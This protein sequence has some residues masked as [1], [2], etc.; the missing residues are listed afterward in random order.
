[1]RETL[2]CGVLMVPAHADRMRTWVDK[3]ARTMARL[4]LHPVSLD[5]GGVVAVC[6]GAAVGAAAVAAAAQSLAR[7]AMALRRFDVCLLPVSPDTLAWTRTALSCAKAVLRTP[8]I[9]VA[10]GLKAAAVEDLLALGMQDFVRDPLCP[11]ELRVRTDRVTAGRSRVGQMPRTDTARHEAVQQAAIH[12]AQPSQ[13]VYGGQAAHGG[14]AAPGDH[15]AQGRHGSLAV[16]EPAPAYA[17]AEGACMPPAPGRGSWPGGVRPRPSQQAFDS[18]L[19]AIQ[20]A[21]RIHPDE[22]FRIAKSRVVDSFERDYVRTALSRHAGNVAR[23]A[24]ASSKH[25]RAFWALMRKHHIDAA[26]YRSRQPQGETCAGMEE[27]PPGK[28]DGLVL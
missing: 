2:D 4:R 6:G 28:I 7:M 21:P 15:A 11:E 23:A 1:M 20:A 8:L 16:Q 19:L 5:E 13:E 18:A 10:R 22:P 9:G 24:R 12:P 27:N 26:P 25:R 17:V 3:H 14:Q